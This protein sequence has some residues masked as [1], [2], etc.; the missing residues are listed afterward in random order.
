[1]VSEIQQRLVMCGKALT[2]SGVCVWANVLI[3]LTSTRSAALLMAL[4]MNAELFMGL[5]FQLEAL[6]EL[7]RKAILT[8]LAA[9]MDRG[10]E[11]D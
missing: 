10:F 11:W 9:N 7:P 2:L 5:W 3:N 8:R 1:M 6:S 4:L